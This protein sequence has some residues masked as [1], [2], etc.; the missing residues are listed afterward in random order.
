MSPFSYSL[1]AVLRFLLGDRITAVSSTRATIAFSLSIVS[2]LFAQNHPTSYV[3]SRITSQPVEYPIKLV[4]LGDNYNINSTFL[5][6]LSGIT[7][8]CPDADFVIL[9]GDFAAGGSISGYTNYLEVIDTFPTPIISVIGNHEQDTPDG[10]SNYLH[11][12][13]SPNVYF[14]YGNWR[15]ITIRNSY[16]SDTPDAWGDYVDYLFE[17]ESLDWLEGL[18][19]ETSPDFKLIF[20]HAPPLIEGYIGIGCV[21]G[22]RSEPSREDSGTDRFT[23]LCRDYAVSLVGMGHVHAYAFI[24]P[25]NEVYGSVVYL[26][27]GGGGGRLTPFPYE[28]PYSGSFYHFV[29]I[30]LSEFGNING[31]VYILEG[32]SIYHEP[33]F[34][35][36]IVTAIPPAAEEPVSRRIYHS[37]VEI[38]DIT[39]RVVRKCSGEAN[40]SALPSGLYFIRG[41][42]ERKVNRILRIK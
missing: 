10:Y 36:N 35:F 6:L 30:E 8:N 33:L 38:I 4:L 7:D 18:L 31:Q 19:E 40:L 9:L 37:G 14:D 20:T 22:W 25:A 2:L 15:F 42:G 24:Q 34:D 27:S 1:S 16:L 29:S 5:T 21:G 23:Q 28:P 26:I 17:M 41:D 12:F 39:G 3:I 32:D 11:F 13:G